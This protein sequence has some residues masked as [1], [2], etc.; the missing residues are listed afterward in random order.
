M[1]EAILSQKLMIHRMR[2]LLEN[3]R[4]ADAAGE[5]DRRGIAMGQAC[6][7]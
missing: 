3:P 1:Q 5:S 6:I 2:N 4:I 7:V